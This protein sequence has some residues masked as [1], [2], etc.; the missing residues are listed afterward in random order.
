LISYW[1]TKPIKKQIKE[2]P[3]LPPKEGRVVTFTFDGKELQGI[4]GMAV[5]SVLFMNDIKVFGEHYV[6]HSPQGIF[7][8][9]GQ[10]AQ[11]TLIIDGKPLKSCMT[12]LKEGMRIE[13]LKG[14]P[15]LPSEDEPVPVSNIQTK[16]VEVLI[17]GGGPSGLSAAKVLGEKN[18]PVLLVDDKDRLGGKLVL[19]THKFFGSAEDVYAGRRGIEIAKILAE[20]LRQL[21]S[22][23]VWLQSTVVGVFSD[24]IVGVL[25]ENENYV[26]IKPKYLLVAT[27]AREKMLTF[28]GNTL[29]GV[30][31]AGAFQTLVN[32]DLVK[33]AEKIFIVGGGNVGLIAGYHA[34]QA[35]IQVVGLV[36]ALPRCGGYKVHEDKL[37]RSGVP[38]FTSHTILSANG[39]NKVESVTIAALDENWHPIAGTEKTFEC[40][41]VLIAV[42]LASVDEFY[43]KAKDFGMEVW[44][45]GDADEIAEASAAIFTGRIAGI[46]ILETMGIDTGENIEQLEQKAEIMKSRPPPPKTPTVFDLE[47]GVFPV[48][49]CTQEIP[50]DPCTSVCPRDLIKMSGDSILSLPYFTNEEPCIGC[51]RCVAVCPGLAITLAD[52]RKDPDF[53]YV[54]L[55]SELGEKRIKKGDIVHIMSNTT[56]I[57]DYKVERVRILKE[58]PKTELVTVKLPKE[59]AKEAT[60]ILVQR[61]ESYSE[62]MEIYHKEALAD[63][64]IVCRCERV[65]AGEIRKWIRRGIVD[66]NELKAITRAGMGACGGKTCNLLI[67]R[68]FREEGIKDVVPGTPRPLFVEVPLGIFAGTKKEEEK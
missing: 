4:E 18:I 3:I 31:G 13:S 12:A 16:E 36:E 14:V 20:D 26:L 52:Y 45:A 63:E 62:P 58:F 32:R 55:P 34:I 41:T 64:A 56:E 51:G 2:H 6:D 29:P 49:H 30:Y 38:I 1:R 33:A 48:F 66:M 65:T 54:T 40:D 39:T 60:G 19:Q 59:Q 24:K 42:G 35:G 8:A 50:C 67:Q 23:E 44:V 46:K 11:C 28:K 43:Q 21:P 5:A 9:N 27:G 10:C 7:C 68:I 47:E 53:V 25:R 15:A 17:I 22:V 61:V 57:G 37:R